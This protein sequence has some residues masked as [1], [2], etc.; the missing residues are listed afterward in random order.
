MILRVI[1]I[2]VVVWR[3]IQLEIAHFYFV[4]VVAIMLRFFFVYFLLSATIRH[5][6]RCEHISVIFVPTFAD[7]LW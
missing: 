5:L 7:Q 2:V 1:V 6:C 4:V 3:S